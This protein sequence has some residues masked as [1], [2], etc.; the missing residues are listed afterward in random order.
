MVAKLMPQ[1]PVLGLTPPKS[2]LKLLLLGGG[3][4]KWTQKCDDGAG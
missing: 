3:R 2:A 1:H 4:I